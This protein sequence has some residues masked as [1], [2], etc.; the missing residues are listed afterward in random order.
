L[1]SFCLITRKILKLLFIV[2]GIGISALVAT[3][4]TAKATEKQ[5]AWFA[6]FASVATVI[7]LVITIVQV[8]ALRSQSAAIKSAVDDT[9]SSLILKVA[10]AD[11]SHCRRIAEE[12][13]SLVKQGE[14]V[15]VTLRLRDLSELIELLT[16]HDVQ[17]VDDERDQILKC[18]EIF[19]KQLTHLHIAGMKNQNASKYD[20][21]KLAQWIDKLIICLGRI[22]HRM[23]YGKE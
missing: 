6:L 13:R 14:L 10:Q 8:S 7:S 12:V 4:L 22:E 2:I 16:S 21:A 18:E 20:D 23:T 1:F 19:Q 5:L 9:K 17:F 15:G 11:I 3:G